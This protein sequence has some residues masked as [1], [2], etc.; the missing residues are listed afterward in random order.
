VAAEPLIDVSVEDVDLREVMDEIGRRVGV[1]ILVEPDVHEKVTISLRQIAWR[2]AVSVIARMTKCQVRGR[3]S[4]LVLTQPPLITAQDM[5]EVGVR[6]ALT[7]LAAYGGKSIIFAKDVQGDGPQFE[8]QNLR[9]ELVFAKTL[10]QDHLYATRRGDVIFVATTPP[11]F[12]TSDLFGATEPVPPKGETRF[13]SGTVDLDLKDAPVGAVLAELTRQVGYPFLLRG[14]TDEK[15]TLTLHAAPWRDAL[16]Y[17]ARVTKL[18]IREEPEG[19]VLVA[20]P[21]NAILATD[22][23]A[24][25][26]FRLMAQQAG[27]SIILPGNMHGEVSVDLHDVPYDEALRVTAEAHGYVVVGEPAVAGEK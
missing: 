7:Q 21:K 5:N 22:A 27:K 12:G 6:T 3:G 10:E 16:G 25:T 26:F 18:K 23:D 19:I 14:T 13:A 17:V 9:I 11:D 2:D 8:I 4:I 1:N 15:L 20:G 24:A